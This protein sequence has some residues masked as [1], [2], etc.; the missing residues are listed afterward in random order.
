ME[1]TSYWGS[2]IYLYRL[3]QVY[4]DYFICPVRVEGSTGYKVSIFAPDGE[5]E[6]PWEMASNFYQLDAALTLA[7]RYID[8]SR[9]AEAL[10]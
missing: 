10:H 1:I 4:R 7:Q 9:P 3:G 8:S 6:C 5:P 2:E